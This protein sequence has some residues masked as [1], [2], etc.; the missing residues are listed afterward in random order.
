[1]AD[2]LGNPVGF[3][4]TGGEAHDLE[5]ADHLLPGMV[6]DT[7]IADKAFD[8][9]ERVRDPLAEAGK[10]AVIPPRA[11]RKQPAE[12]DRHLYQARH[13]IENFF[14]RLKQYRAIATRYD[15]TARNFLA[16]IHLAAAVTWLN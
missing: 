7:L 6:A 12:F 15:K 2:A 16:A 14:A 13:L 9:D 3:H 8:A 10:A 1:M 11:N 5:G 4:L